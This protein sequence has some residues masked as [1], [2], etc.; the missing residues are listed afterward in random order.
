MMNIVEVNDDVIWILVSSF[1]CNDLAQGQL[2]ENIQLY[3]DKG[4]VTPKMLANQNI[5]RLELKGQ[6]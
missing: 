2:R 4:I 6:L 5:D 3:I 1:N